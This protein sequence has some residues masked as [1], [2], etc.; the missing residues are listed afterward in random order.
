MTESQL[1]HKLV[2][3]SHTVLGLL[4]EHLAALRF[5]AAGYHVTAAERGR[6]VGDLRV[7]DKSSGEF[8]RVEVK[9][10]RATRDRSGR[11]WRFV[12]WKRD[13]TSHKNT[14]YVLLIAYDE[15]PIFFL[16]PSR[17]VHSQNAVVISSRPG[18]YN[19]RFAKYRAEGALKL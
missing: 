4:G 12:L 5:R 8:W 1:K 18:R 13:H 14:D 16:I 11:K 17:A 2:D 7:A 19:G 15:K 3:A 9:T 10:A 6:K